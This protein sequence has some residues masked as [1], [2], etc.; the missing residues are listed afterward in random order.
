MSVRAGL[1]RS[2]SRGVGLSGSGRSGA[3]VPATG[4]GSPTGT[5]PP[6][7]AGGWLGA[8]VVVGGGPSPSGTLGLPEV[9]VPLPGAGGDDAVVVWGPS[10]AGV[11]VEEPDVPEPEP[12]PELRTVAIDSLCEVPGTRCRRLWST[13]SPVRPARLP[14]VRVNLTGTV[15]VVVGLVARWTA[16]A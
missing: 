5:E 14:A 9:S 13:P 10:V 8:G 11:A 15:L 3:G 2:C 7:G 1:W 16:A 12:G 4:L 6:T